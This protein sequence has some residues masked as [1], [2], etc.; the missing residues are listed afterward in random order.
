MNSFVTLVHQSCN[1]SDNY[2]Y[3]T[4]SNLSKTYSV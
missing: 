3:K 2:V 4:E 1:R